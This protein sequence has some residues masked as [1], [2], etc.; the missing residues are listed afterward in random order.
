MSIF[1][2]AWWGAVV[3]G[4]AG[5]IGCHSYPHTQVGWEARVYKPGLA[6][7]APAGTVVTNNGA[8][9]LVAVDHPT[10]LGE[11]R[12]VAADSCGV[13]AESIR[14]APRARVVEV[15]AGASCS[16]E[17]VCRRLLL[18]ERQLGVTSPLPSPRQ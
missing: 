14:T 8:T 11:Q 5:A 7:A 18:I 4:S 16:L 3:L 6:V 12:V 13:V 1:Q 2:R 9:G 15:Q 10:Q 17:D